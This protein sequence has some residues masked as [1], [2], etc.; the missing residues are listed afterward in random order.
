MNSN[1]TTSDGGDINLLFL[2]G[3]STRT[4]VLSKRLRNSV[5]LK[6]D[7]AWGAIGGKKIRE[8]G[9]EK[10]PAKAMVVTRLLE[11]IET[12]I[13]LIGGKSRA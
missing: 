5:S 10:R 1:V 12:N 13:Y 9:T 6:V 7:I 11:E 8:A 4:R 3:G 2:G